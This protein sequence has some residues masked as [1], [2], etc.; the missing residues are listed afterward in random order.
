MIQEVNGRLTRHQPAGTVH[1]RHVLR[2]AIALQLGRLPHIYF[3]QIGAMDGVSSDPL[4]PLID[5]F[6]LRGVLIEPQRDIF[7][8]L[9]AN[10]SR[11]G[12]G[13]FIFVRGAIAERDGLVS[14]YRVR[15]DICGTSWLRGIASLSRELVKWHL[16]VVLRRESSIV[17]E[18]VPCYSV[19]SL[20]KR[21]RLPKIDLLQ[22]D[23]EGSDGGILA[24]FNIEVRRP[25][26][27]NFEHKHLTRGEYVFWLWRLTAL[28]YTVVRCEE[29]IVAELL[30]SD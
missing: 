25:V 14:L 23:A 11:F 6:G 20:I 21:W 3:M 12:E 26:I 10:Y 29:D 8:E 5:E 28:G 18:M 1:H 15:P 2:E 9:K 24:Q 4:Y 27:I 17:S 16:P 13:R 22:I 30:P 7:E 19:E